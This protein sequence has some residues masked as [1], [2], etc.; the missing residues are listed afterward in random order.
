MTWHDKF[1]REF[2]RHK[3]YDLP[4]V[5]IF[6]LLHLLF[7]V[8]DGN[9]CANNP[10]EGGAT[11]VDGNFNFT[12]VCSNGTLG[13]QCQ[14]KYSYL[15]CLSMNIKP[16][17]WSFG[18]NLV[19]QISFWTQNVTVIYKCLLLT[20]VVSTVPHVCPTNKSQSNLN[21][22]L[23]LQ[24]FSLSKLNKPAASICIISRYG[25]LLPE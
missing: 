8:F 20:G 24:M 14:C 22:F 13:D 19:L 10:C 11:C 3:T 25:P 4:L 5:L 21:L 6:F 2:D 7:K 1:Y 12:C 9:D 16:L 18:Y 17:V 23:M 15:N